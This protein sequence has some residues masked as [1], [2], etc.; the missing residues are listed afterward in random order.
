MQHT[1]ICGEDA[2]DSEAKVRA[3][4]VDDIGAPNVGKAQPQHDGVVETEEDDLNE[5]HHHQLCGRNAAY[6][7]PKADEHCSGSKVAIDE[8]AIERRLMIY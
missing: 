3:K 6:H 1:Y 7:R 8:T 2:A 5:G 4:H